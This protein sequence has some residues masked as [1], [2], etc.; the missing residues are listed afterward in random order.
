MYEKITPQFV[1][2]CTNALEF[3]DEN[4]CLPWDRKKVTVTLSEAAI[5]KLDGKNKSQTIEKSLS[6]IN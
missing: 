6:Y 2:E 4:N 3:F 1:R 5:R